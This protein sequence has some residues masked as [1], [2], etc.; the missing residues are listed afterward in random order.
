MT[1][2]DRPTWSADP[3]QADVAEVDRI[4][5]AVQ[6]NDAVPLP[7]LIAIDL[8]AL[9]GAFQAVFDEPVWRAWVNLP[10]GYRDELAGDAFR[11]LVDRRLMDPPRSEPAADGRPLARIA[12]PLALIMMTRSQPA[13]IVQCARNGEQRGAPRMYGIAQ[14]AVGVQAVLVERASNERVGL[15]VREHVV[16]P[17][18]EDLARADDLHQLYKYLLLSPTR[19]VTV[20]AS[21]AC[22][23]RPGDTRTVD[24]YRHR[25]GE[26]PSRSRLMVDRQPDGELVVRRDGER[27]ASTVE[28][29]GQDMVAGEVTNMV[30]TETT[31]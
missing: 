31:A 16:L 20:L 23:D 14:D 10:D 5:A 26:Q 19:A 30:I 17:A 29:S 3:R 7:D 28:R 18:S 1:Q 8:C 27:R 24:V 9:G 6:R 21:W 13:F 4:L 15:G 25:G 2:P 12:P 11:G 22:A